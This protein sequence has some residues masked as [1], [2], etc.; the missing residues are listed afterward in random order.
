MERLI[1]W[2]T[3]ATM[4]ASGITFGLILWFAVE[5]YIKEIRND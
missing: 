3:I 2:V 5:D 1:A 4:I